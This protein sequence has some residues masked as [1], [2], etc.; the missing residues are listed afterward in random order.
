MGRLFAIAFTK[1]RP[2]Q[3]KKTTYAQ[4]SQIRQIRKKMIEIMEREASS[5]TL[6]GLVSKLIPEMIGREI[7]KATQDIFPLQ[8]VYIRKV[9]LLK[10][11]KFDLSQLLSLHG[12][13]G[14]DA[15]A[16]VQEGRDFVE[17]PVQESV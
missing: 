13:S 2:N 7:E 17:P 6:P 15:G 16:A 3:I 12:E 5:C 4:S 1:R 11:P 9:K 10:S 14:E 8:H